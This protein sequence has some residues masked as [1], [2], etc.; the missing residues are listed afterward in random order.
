MNQFFATGGQ[1]IE[2][3]VSASV[4]PIFRIDFLELTHTHTHTQRC[5]FHHRGQNAKVESEE[6]SGV[7]GKFGL[8]KQHEAGQ[9]LIEF[10]QENSL[11]IGNTLF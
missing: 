7:T 8:G 10:C 5:P 3:S 9:R 1:S 2:A 6:I 4:L 11:I